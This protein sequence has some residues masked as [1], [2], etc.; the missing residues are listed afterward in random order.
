MKHIVLFIVITG[1]LFS[2]CG[3][4]IKDPRVKKMANR[5]CRNG[6]ILK[7]VYNNQQSFTDSS[8]VTGNSYNYSISAVNYYFKES[9]LSALVSF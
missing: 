2:A 9:G 7:E 4:D 8:C 5:I 6:T 1:I 3:K